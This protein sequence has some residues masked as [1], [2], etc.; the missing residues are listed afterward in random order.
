MV[1]FYFKLNSTVYRFMISPVQFDKLME[2]RMKD[3]KVKNKE[4]HFE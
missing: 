2:A 4:K 3:G 1:F